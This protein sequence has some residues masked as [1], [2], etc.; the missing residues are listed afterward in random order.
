MSYGSG[1]MVFDMLAR[2]IA[3]EGTGTCF[4]LLGDANMN[5]ATRLGDLG[6]R[7]IYVR[8]EHCAVAAAMAYAR[9]TGEVGLATVT[10]GPGLTQL[11]TALPAAVRANIPLVVL[12][13]E[14][15][16]SKGWYNQA[17]DQA[18][19]VTATG[20]SYRALHWPDRMPTA[21]RDAFLEAR[22]TRKPVV[23]GVPFD[24]QHGAW[25]GPADLPAPSTDILPRISPMPPN[26]DDVARAADLVAGA[27]RIVVMA[28][29]GAA[30]AGAAEACLALAAKLDAAL[31]T[32]LPARGLFVG[33]PHCLGVAGGF[34]SDVAR[35]VFA[36]TDLVIAVGSSLASHNADAGKLWP[37]ARVLQIDT[38]PQA[39]SQ[40][41][42]ASHAHLRADARLGVEALTK[43]VPQRPATLCTAEL[44]ER[45]ATTPADGSVFPQESGL[46]DP[47]DVVA[48]LEEHLPSHWQMV[49]SS[50]HC[51]YYFAHMPS[52]RHDTFLTIREFG[53]IGNGTSFAMGVAAAKPGDTVVLFDGD[54]SF[55]M[56]VQ[57]LET[58][59]RHGLNILIIVLNDRAYGSEIHKLRAEGLSDAGAVFG[60]TD[61]AAIARG[62]GI[63]GETITDLAALPALIADFAATGGAAVWDVPISD[64]VFSPVIRRAHPELAAE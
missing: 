22:M 19:F 9:K 62:F 24:L 4:A 43:A 29:L 46:H 32:T 31:A 52:R 41:R 25:T 13:G 27:A 59:R 34:S 64:R 51:S 63:G 37:K 16:M 57:E 3:Q 30:E 6:T 42:L 7:M 18:P 53:A 11:M 35:A 5:V 12:A 50:G 33:H 61:L 39:I 47:R 1:P 36:E 44:A 28:G 14:A 58:I 8:H 20:A 21:I 56:H 55:L 60:P 49:N 38:D 17:I 48:A 10:C 26:P 40:G 54:G 15:P 23:L 2:A 45:I